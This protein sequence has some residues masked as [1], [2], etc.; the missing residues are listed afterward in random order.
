VRVNACGLNPAAWGLCR[1]LFAGLLPCGVGLDVSGVVE[2]IGE[3]VKDVAVGDAV[4]GR[5]NFAEYPSA[6]TADYAS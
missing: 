2:E 4:F 5:V 6:G 3:G 1:G